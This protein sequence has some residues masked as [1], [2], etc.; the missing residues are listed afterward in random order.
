MREGQAVTPGESTR[1]ARTRVTHTR[2]R[3]LVRRAQSVI[4]QAT[5]QTQWIQNK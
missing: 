2:I 5:L 1:C 4:C 3:V